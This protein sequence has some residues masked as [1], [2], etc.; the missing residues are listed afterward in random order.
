VIA[1]DLSGQRALVAGAGRGIGRE[2]ALIL[3]RAGARLVCADITSERVDEVV[4]EVECAGGTAVPLVVDLTSRAGVEQAVG[5][6]LD[7]YGGID[8]CVDVIGTSSWHRLLDVT[9]EEWDSSHDLV[10]RHAF[11]L[12][13]V[14]GRAMVRQGS[15]G[16][17]ICIT[18]I[19]GHSAAPLHGPYGAFKA[20]LMALAKTFAVELGPFGIRVN[21]V[22][23]GAILGPR[24]ADSVDA[25]RA[26]GV[27]S[28][29]E[30]ALPIPLR[31]VGEPSDIASAVLFLVSDLAG[32]LSGQ[33]LL[34]DGGAS[35]HFPL[36][37]KGQLEPAS[38]R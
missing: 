32:Y 33:A 20:A 1:V 5:R 28:G 35:A 7:E 37:S 17:L 29:F 34:V 36:S 6:T 11:L 22:S 38:E 3:A 2:I 30:M 18:S 25:L 14:A 23:P 10:L 13:Q 15:G 26:I 21:A 27:E 8:I 4:D 12:F 24:S 16:S 9:D 19:S 31:R